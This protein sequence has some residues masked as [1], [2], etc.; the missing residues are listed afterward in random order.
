MKLLSKALLAFC[1]PLN[2][3]VS[4]NAFHHAKNVHPPALAMWSGRTFWHVAKIL[5]T[6]AAHKIMSKQ[7]MM[8][9]VKL[10]AEDKWLQPVTIDSPCL[11]SHFKC[12]AGRCSKYLYVTLWLSFF[13][14]VVYE[15][16]INITFLYFLWSSV[17][18]QYFYTKQS[19]E[20]KL[21]LQMCQS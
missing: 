12:S 11:T 16:P 2:P 7:M 17:T 15:Q 20:S 18:N 8:L 14:D 19:N 5:I 21:A 1:K 3:K 10:K 9:I 13:G 4:A 6:I